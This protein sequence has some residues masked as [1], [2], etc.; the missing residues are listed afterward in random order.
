MCLGVFLSTK[1]STGFLTPLE[2]MHLENKALIKLNLFINVFNFISLVMF[3]LEWV[4]FA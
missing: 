2:K 4:C 1:S 3:A